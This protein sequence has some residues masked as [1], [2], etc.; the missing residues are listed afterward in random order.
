MMFLE[1][2]NNF[3]KYKRKFLSFR[4]YGIKTNNAEI[5]LLF[6][7]TDNFSLPT[8]KILHKNCNCRGHGDLG[9]VTSFKNPANCV[10]EYA[11][12]HNLLLYKWPVSPSD[13]MLYDIGIV[14]SFG[15]LIP[16]SVIQA[17][18]LGMINVH[19][20]LLPRWRGAAPIIHAIMNGDTETG[21][22][23]MRIEPKRFDVGGVFAQCCVPIKPHVLMP[24]LHTQLAEEGAKLLMKVIKTYPQSF[25]KVEV[26]NEDKVTYA[27]KI[28]ERLTEANWLTMSSLQLY[29]RYRALYG[30]KM[31]N[32]KFLGKNLN[33]IDVRLPS[34]NST[35]VI[36][37]NFPDYEQPGSFVFSKELK[38][39]LVL[40][41]QRTHIEVH[42]LRLEGKKTMTAADFNN[43]FI[44]KLNGEKSTFT[45]N[46][47]SVLI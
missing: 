31:L 6:F 10:R 23:I 40:C 8:L 17:F 41:A 3:Y 36:S 18:P 30:Y 4:N 45:C 29:N 2:L 43:G 42:Q 1:I 15:H 44:K 47:S 34:S 46:K 33:L 35:D 28:T 16:T 39:L 14:V 19:A 37:N 24:E 13:C 20:S 27:P 21:V 9:V 11:Q 38:C 22:S 25:E 26:Q 32:T 12:Q 5:K 7:G